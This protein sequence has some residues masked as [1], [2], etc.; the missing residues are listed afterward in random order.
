MAEETGV[1]NKLLDLMLEKIDE[2]HYPST[3]MMDLAEELLRPEDVERYTDVLMSKIS[4]ENY[5]SL[6]LVRRAMAFA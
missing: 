6:D 5:P 4:S 2:D 1:R 3:T